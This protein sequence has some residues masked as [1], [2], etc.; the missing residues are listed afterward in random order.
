MSGEKML[1]ET[2]AE[3]KEFLA[4]KNVL[5]TPVDFGDKALI[6][7]ARYGFGFG[8]GGGQG[9]KGGGEGA[10]AGG[11]IEPVALVILHKDIKGPE[12]VQVLSVRKDSTIAQVVAILSET[13]APQVI[14]AIKGMNKAPAP[15]DE[16][17]KE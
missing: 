16:K 6:P 11:G 7:V 15:K 4:S 17:D 12:G 10:G 2:A 1:K 14:E 5:G 13:L 3:L 9:A 8:A